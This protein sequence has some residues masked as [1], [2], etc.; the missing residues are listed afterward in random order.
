MNQIVYLVVLPKIDRRLVWGCLVGL[1]CVL[2]TFYCLFSVRS[3]RALLDGL[4]PIH[5]IPLYSIVLFW[6]VCMLLVSVCLSVYCV[7]LDRYK[8]C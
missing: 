5:C 7:G 4:R 2:V 8:V 3:M 1:C 6:S